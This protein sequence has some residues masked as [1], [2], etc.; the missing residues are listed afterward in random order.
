MCVTPQGKQSIS[1]EVVQPG[2][3]CQIGVGGANAQNPQTAP[4]SSSNPHGASLSSGGVPLPPSSGA[5]SAG[6]K[7]GAGASMAGLGAS[8]SAGGAGFAAGDVI[9][10]TVDI[11]SSG[12]PSVCFTNQDGVVLHST[13]LKPPPTTR[14]SAKPRARPPSKPYDPSAPSSVWHPRTQTS[15]GKSL[16]DHEEVKLKQFENDWRRALR[17]GIQSLIMRYDDDA[18]DD[19]DGDGIPD[20]VEDVAAALWENRDIWQLV[21]AYYVSA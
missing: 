11:S 1:I 14:K 21:F 20:E 16:Y 8:S 17:L 5:T 12:A 18:D 2:L 9:T 4:G 3:G 15:D 6:S 10:I 19:D 13:T 7:G